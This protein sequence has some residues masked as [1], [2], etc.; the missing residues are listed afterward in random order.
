MSSSSEAPAALAP[1]QLRDLSSVEA[2]HALARTLLGSL[3]ST[4]RED[5][6]RDGFV[7][8]RTEGL[9]EAR[10]AAAIEAERARSARRA[11]EQ[12]RAE[13]HAAALAALESAAA[14]VRGQLGQLTADIE[15][16]ATTLAFALADTIMAREVAEAAPA[17][18]VRRVLQVLPPT[19]ATSPAAPVTTVR[20][21]PVVATTGVAQ[22]LLALGLSVVADETLGPADALVESDGSVLDLR[23]AA[24][25]ARV[26]EA[27]G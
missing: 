13:E 15:S 14:Q 4:A 23:I 20:L 27:L 21:H 25:M 22:D 3:A 6:Y 16:R 19:Q 18:V 1:M 2:P 8:G 17:D 5:G 12:R 26:R 11:S 24:A 9:A 7:A 10:A